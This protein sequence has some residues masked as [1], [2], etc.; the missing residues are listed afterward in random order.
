MAA[1]ENFDQVIRSVKESQLNFT[2]NLTPFSAHIVIK[3]S[4]VK[5]FTP[6]PVPKPLKLSDQIHSRVIQGNQHLLEQIT[7]L[8]KSNNNFVYTIKTLEDKI[9]NAEASVYKTFEERNQ[10]VKTLKHALKNK[11]VELGNLQKEIKV[12]EKGLKEKE[13]EEYK[14][15]QKVENLSDNLKR[16]K[17]EISTLKSENKNLLKRKKL[18]KDS[19]TTMQVTQSSSCSQFASIKAASSPTST[20]SSSFMASSSSTSSNSSICLNSTLPVPVNISDSTLSI[21]PLSPCLVETNNNQPLLHLDRTKPSFEALIPEHESKPCTPTRCTP[22][23]RSASTPASTTLP[24]EC[25]DAVQLP[26]LFMEQLE[27]LKEA[28]KL[29]EENLMKKMDELIKPNEDKN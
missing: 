9:S 21:T 8:E 15:I 14:L 18:L 17:S 3:S 27:S 1:K 4:F 26:A 10:E 19:S 13:K 11:D 16:S 29:R 25:T 2:M 24:T 20:P 22:S 7:N 5:N 23:P 12:L 6:P 28:I